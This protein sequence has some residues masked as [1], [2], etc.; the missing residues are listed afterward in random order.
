MAI[1]DKI[2]NKREKREISPSCL[3]VP[4][5]KTIPQAKIKITTVRTAVARFELTFLMPIFAKTAVMAAKNADKK[6]KISQNI[7]N[8]FQLSMINYQ[9]MTKP[10]LH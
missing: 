9:L 1:P 6:A 4:C 10:Q 8:N 7:I 3:K 5:A 2:K